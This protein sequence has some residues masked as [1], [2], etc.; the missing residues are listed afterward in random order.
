MSGLLG[1]LRY[2]VRSAW[3]GLR[4]GPLPAV[5]AVATI[6]VSLFLVGVF[7]LVLTNMSGILDRFG[8]EVRLTAYV[9]DGL[10]APAQRVLL[11][12]VRRTAGVAGAEWVS[13][14]A[15]LERF[16]ERLGDEATLLEGL[17]E[18]PL[19]ASVE[20]DLAPSERSA[21]GLDRVAKALD[22]LPGIDEVARGHAWVE[23]YARAVA[24]LRAAAVGLGGVLALAAFVIVTNT[25]RL[26]VYAR[27][28]EIDILMLVG[29]TRTFVSVP[30]LIEGVVQ[31]A[32]GGLVALGLLYGA[33]AALAGG[34]AAAALTFVLGHADPVFLSPAA[35][36]GLVAA[37]A[38]LGFIGS[39]AALLQGLRA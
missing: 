3:L 39:A 34:S 25:I 10:D 36:A 29:A 1:Q 17:E 19:P 27:R 12:R 21:E 22:A 33:F 18:N 4:G 35:S 37:G 13:R 9:A 32:L 11:E 30:F 16:R 6:A 31:G 28:D 2:F 8:R 24:L 7:A 38:G 20:V 15:A 14:E 26:A 23:G 5:V